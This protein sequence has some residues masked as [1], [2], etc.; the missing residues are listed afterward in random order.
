MFCQEAADTGQCAARTDADDD[1]IDI[2]LHLSKDFWSGCSLMRSWIGRISK[3]ID[4][5]RSRS[6]R[7]NGLGKILIIIWMAAADV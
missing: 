4:V 7:G 1:S 6:T 3:L 2:A 5:D